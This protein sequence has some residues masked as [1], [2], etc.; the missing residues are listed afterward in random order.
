V[1]TEEELKKGKNLFLSR[2][3]KM[4]RPPIAGVETPFKKL[5]ATLHPNASLPAHSP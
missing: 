2:A 3:K 1:E 5:S 4:Q